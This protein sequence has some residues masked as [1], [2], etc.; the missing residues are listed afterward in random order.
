MKKLHAILWT[1]AGVAAFAV[2]AFAQ[3]APV[4]IYD[5]NTPLDSIRKQGVD[6]KRLDDGSLQIVNGVDDKWPGV[7]FEGDWKLD[8]YSAIE[9]TVESTCDKEFTL[10]FRMDSKGVDMSTLAGAV[11]ESV[12]LAPGEKK[13]VKFDLPGQLNPETRQKL[14]AMRGKP[15]GIKTDSYSVDKGASFN[16]RELVAFRPFVNQ[17]KERNSW[18]LVSIVALPQTETPEGYLSWGPDK[19][20]PMIDEFGQ[21][22]H[23]DWTGKTHSLEELRAQIEIEDADLAANQ[24]CEFDEYGGWKN[25]PQLEATGSFRTEKI[26]GYWYL[27]D[28]N[29]YLFWSNGVDCVGHSNAVT[30]LSEREFYFCD[31]IPTRP[32]P[33]NKL[34]Q[35]LWKS[36]NSVNNFYADYG[37]FW[38]FNFSAS[39][40]YKK[41]GDNWVDK[42]KDLV[43]R[44]LRSWG[45]NTIGNWSDMNIA[46]YSKTPYVTTVNSGSRAIEGSSGY[47]GK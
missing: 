22:M 35:F 1:L 31:A 37:E 20:F 29:G 9:L 27:V 45:L 26:D 23:K 33:N 15:G 34:S 18:K 14:F 17:N 10:F 24:P 44:R 12:K 4:V 47:W 38:T 43:R 32:D 16:R 2:Q 8:A 41:F 46:H 7:H 19:F 30:P 28:P 21:F 39:N 6:V 13:T 3:N 25:G 5:Q 42:E 11:T 36:S 40:L